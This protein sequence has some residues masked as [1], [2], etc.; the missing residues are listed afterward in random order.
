MKKIKNFRGVTLDLFFG[1]DPELLVR[2]CADPLL[3]EEESHPELELD[4]LS[5]SVYNKQHFT[6]V[7]IIK[8]CNLD[9]VHK[10]SQWQ[11]YL[12]VGSTVGPEELFGKF[13]SNLKDVIIKN[14]PMSRE[15]QCYPC[16]LS[17]ELIKCQ[18]L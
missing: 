16:W 8:K 5:N 9:E 14:C 2:H 12:T 10:W 7:P 15:G 1:T 3:H 6:L 17:K 18:E 4:I 11:P 13:C